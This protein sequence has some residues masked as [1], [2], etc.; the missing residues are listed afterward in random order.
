MTARQT[1]LYWREWAAVRLERP[2]FADTDR[3]ALH[4]A[5]LG[6]DVSSKELTNAQFD[7]VLAEFR[8]ITRPADLD[9]QVRQINQPRARLLWKIEHEQRDCLALYVDAP[10]DYILALAR[11]KFGGEA[12]RRL[13]N[14]QLDHL[15]Y[16][17]A[18]AIDRLRAAA[19]HGVKE[20]LALARRS[21]TAATEKERA[22]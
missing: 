15:R 9:G 7:K 20:M 5:A 14:K 21:Q 13:T 16:T 19:G 17:L 6:R 3:H 22:A 18:R 12:L 4:E 1:A 8:A 10:E 11:D 2:H